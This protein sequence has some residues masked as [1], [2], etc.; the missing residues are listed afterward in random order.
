[1]KFINKKSKRINVK[2][3]YINNIIA[4]TTV[5]IIT[6]IAFTTPCKGDLPSLSTLTQSFFEIPERSSAPTEHASGVTKD[7]FFALLKLFSKKFHETVVNNSQ[8][9]DNRN[10]DFKKLDKNNPQRY[11]QKKV[12][13]DAT[14]VTVAGDYHGSIHSFIRNLWRLVALGH[15]NPDL[16]IKNPN[17]VMVFLGDYVD[18]GNWGVEV[19]TTLITLK[20]KNWDKVFILVGNHETGKTPYKYGFVEELNQKYGTGK[21][22]NSNLE[23]V[24]E[25]FFTLLPV[26][27][28]LQC[29]NNNIQCCHGGIEK[30]FNPKSFL[31]SNATYCN[32]GTEDR[33]NGLFWSDFCHSN[34][35]DLEF[36]EKRGK[37]YIA[38][39]DVTR[40]YLTANNLRAILRGHQDQYGI[41]MFPDK[42]TVELSKTIHPT[43][44]Y[45]EDKLYEWGDVIADYRKNLA[46]TDIGD[47]FPLNI[48]EYPVITFSSAVEARDFPWDTFGILTLSKTWERCMMEIC[49]YFLG[50]D[51]KVYDR[52]NKF[53]TVSTQDHKT[54]HTM[55]NSINNDDKDPVCVQWSKTFNKKKLDN[56]IATLC[57]PAKKNVIFKSSG[58]GSLGIDPKAKQQTQ[59]SGT[60]NKTVPDDYLF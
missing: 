7:T 29:G 59:P 1:M 35:K 26:G 58:S 20:L 30:N 3:Q 41:L 50:R 60:K 14:L 57:E 6:L 56:G 49:T 44:I 24:F 4:A 54:S 38:N 52:K 8:W 5:M 17:M 18:R 11:V 9:L 23:A 21:T 32:V 34:A 33:C 37:A 48:L 27:L 45:K 22:E 13:N 39:Q 51:R 55:R 15:L 19:L 12:L 43:N 46:R 53:P 10:I 25:H 16:S 40:K 2:K 47:K 36:N 42:K 28:L 31:K